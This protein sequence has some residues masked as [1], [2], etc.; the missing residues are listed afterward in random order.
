M[1]QTKFL[2]IG[3][4]ACGL[5]AVAGAVRADVVLSGYN[6]FYVLD[7][8][9]GDGQNGTYTVN[10]N[11]VLDGTASI[12]CNDNATDQPPGPVASGASACNIVIVVHGDLTMQAGSAIR[13]ENQS[14][15][16]SGGN[17]TITVDG[18]VLLKGGVPAGA[19]ISSRKITGAGDTGIGGN[20]TIN[21]GNIACEASPTKGDVTV[22][23]GAQ[24]LADS[25]GNPGDIV[26]HSGRFI[27]IDGK[28]S[29][30]NFT[31]VGRAG[32]ITIV[33]CCDLTVGETGLVQ[34]IG[35]DPGADL[36]HL[37]ACNVK[38][39]GLVQST[40]P[41]HGDTGSIGP[42]AC[43][44]ANHVAP[45]GKKFRACVEIWGGNTV[46]IDASGTNNGQVNA[47]TAQGGGSSGMG[48]ID[49]YANGNIT[50]TGNTAPPFAIHANTGVDGSICGVIT[51]K[52]KLGSVTATDLAVQA[53]ADW[54]VYF[55]NGVANGAAG[56]SITM[57][58]KTNLT[59][60][61]ATIDATGDYVPT[62][63]KG[64]R[65]VLQAAT[66]GTGLFWNGT[67]VD[68]RP[69]GTGVALANRGT[70]ETDASCATT[71]TP[72]LPVSSGAQTNPSTVAACLAAIVIPDPANS[73]LVGRESCLTGDCSHE[74]ELPPDFCTKAPVRA[75]LDPVTGQF[76]GNQGPDLIV[77]V[78]LGDKIQD[79]LDLA[80]VPGFDAAHNND[81]YIIIAVSAHAD[82]S[83]GGDTNQAALIDGNYEFPF[84]LFGCSVTMHSS[85]AVGHIAAGATAPDNPPLSGLN[86]FVMDLHGSDGTYG[87]LI[88]G[89]GRS[90][91]NTYGKNSGTGVAFLGNNN[92]MHNGQ[93]TGNSGVG[94]LIQGNGNYVTDTDVFSNGSHGV[95]V[96]G[97]NNQIL[98]VDAGDKGKGNT[99][100]G[101]N[102]SGTGNTLQ[103]IDAFANT[104]WG[105]NVSGGTGNI[106]N[107]NNGGDR[108]KGNTA[109]GFLLD[110][111]V[112]L[113]QNTAIG[114]SGNGFKFMS[115]GWNLKNNVSGGTGSGQPNG[116]CQFNFTVAGN[117]NQG[118]NKY[119]G[120]TLSGSPIAVACKN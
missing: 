37:E 79:A 107:K 18:N 117:V 64:G 71:G 67:T 110:G 61:G 85:G 113:L 15:G 119:D 56:G 60:T 52:S 68:V 53:G 28:V 92:L 72:I 32:R 47:D 17:I 62:I 19:L 89:N 87:W 94:L 57:G 58:A 6:S 97:N 77:R 102:V 98:K 108:G 80:K 55:G 8:G 22:E 43:N 90:V 95:Q 7:A 115:S 21:A 16:G 91:R 3:I 31:T 63:A 84:A 33:A 116:G 46:L 69:T 101:V 27:T 81:G 9:D 36:V 48:W 30:Q 66:G 5:L 39:F 114:N 78:D 11:L 10:D 65:V 106:L 99:G 38:V 120:I 49:V 59:L 73:A 70:I 104:G 105:F 100:D 88:E 40:G 112:T 118:G 12:N 44:D 103:E 96:I 54:N 111:S 1:K 4:L 29:S 83:L 86:I 24:I 42:D 45:T 13:A 109:G 20:I 35:R 51:V 23:T 2:L 76:P 74:R 93:G 41:G 14:G 26:I 75:V 82:H 25:P 34:S 50:I